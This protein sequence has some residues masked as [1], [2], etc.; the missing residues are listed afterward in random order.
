MFSYV[1]LGNSLH[2]FPMF[3]RQTKIFTCF[4]DLFSWK[5]VTIPSSVHTQEVSGHL[6]IL[7]GVYYEKL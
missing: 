2:V 4:P 7:R 5:T 1:C 6:N 3:S